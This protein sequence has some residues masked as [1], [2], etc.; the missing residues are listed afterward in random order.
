ML[1]VVRPVDLPEVPAL[2]R[3]VDPAHPAEL[4][5]WEHHS[6]RAALNLYEAFQRKDDAP[7][8]TVI[9][10]R[11]IERFMSPRA[12]LAFQ[13]TGDPVV[14]L[15]RLKILEVLEGRGRIVERFSG[16]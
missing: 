7:D 13:D 11:I 16:R 9:Q 6:P 2:V 12:L 15:K 5:R 1:F 14:L 10:C 4:A 8:Y 3:M